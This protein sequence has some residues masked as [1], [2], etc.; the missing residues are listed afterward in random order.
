MR[1]FVLM[2]AALSAAAPALAQAQS[3]QPR[4]RDTEAAARGVRHGDILPLPAVRERVRIPGAT[5][6]GADLLSNGFIYRL[7]F[8]RGS[9]VM[10]VDVDARTGRV[11]GCMGC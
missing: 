10:F 5:L 9:N 8:M 7:R 11:L 3:G 2:I 6:I 1:K 4:P